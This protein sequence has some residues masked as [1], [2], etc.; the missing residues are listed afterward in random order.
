[1]SSKSPLDQFY[2][3]PSIVDGVLQ[4]I[5][6]SRYD[7]VIEPSAG[8][9]D[10]FKRLPSSAR[11]GIDLQP[12]APGIEEGDFLKFKPDTTGSILTIG[13]PPFG[14]NSSLAVKFFN[15][16]ATFSDCIAFIVPRTFRKPTIIN[17][18]NPNFH[19]IKQ[20]L[21]PLDAFYTPTEESYS[22]P[23]VFQVWQFREDPRVRVKSYD[24]HPDFDFLGTDC[25]N[26]TD[27]EVTIACASAH[28][29]DNAQ[30][31]YMMSKEELVIL[32][33]MRKKYPK[34]FSS[35]RIAKAKKLLSWE[36]KPDFAWRRAGSRA[37]EVFRDY[38]S[39]PIEGFDFIKV[40]TEG[41][42]EI[43]EKMWENV[44]NPENNSSRANEKW[45]T[46]GQPSVS[47][48]ELIKLY[49]QTKEQYE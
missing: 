26:F 39:R 17:R 41:V 3:K 15:H 35:H 5:D 38:A 13:N 14:K 40:N 43:F 10:F 49:I 47:R 2:T 6:C 24:S 25:Y 33:D 19:L 9:G 21:L 31:T 11:I 30:E 44:W 22:V 37:G 27:V 32:K 46:A 42:C 1:M 28:Y 4:M 36:K 20:E 29:G 16:A 34:M 12:A 7:T 8:A 18:L 45:D 23:T 48:H